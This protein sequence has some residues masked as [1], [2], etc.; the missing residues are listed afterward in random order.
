LLDFTK[1]YEF[2]LFIASCEINYRCCKNTPTKNWLVSFY[3]LR[4]MPR[5]RLEAFLK[6][7]KYGLSRIIPGCDETRT[8]FLDSGAFSFQN[9]FGCIDGRNNN[10]K[11]ELTT[12]ALMTY[13]LDYLEFVKQYG[14]YFDIIV[15]VDVDYIIGSK[16][17][18]YMFDR[19]RQ[20][21]VDIRPVWHIPKGDA[22]W[23]KDSKTF[24]YMGIEGQTR[25]RDDPISF[26]NQ[27]MKIAHENDCRIHGFAMTD[28]GVLDRVPF[29]SVDSASWMLQAANG[30]VKTPF[31][32]IAISDRSIMNGEIGDVLNYASLNT[33]QKAEFSDYV[34]KHGFTVDGLKHEWKDRAALNTYYYSWME[35]KINRKWS[36][37]NSAKVYQRPLFTV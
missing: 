23:E 15:E 36:Y 19:M 9:A 35:D 4:K 5:E 37:L 16:K 25:H 1:K 27:K 18:R 22:W 33:L 30:T 28:F 10:D 20:D 17:T 29:D 26:Y 21:G 24:N 34:T 13:M 11:S 32:T 7:A 2:K 12:Y 31:G 14:H 3:Y 8:L 6:D